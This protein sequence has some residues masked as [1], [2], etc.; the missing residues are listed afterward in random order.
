VIASIDQEAIMPVLIKFT[1][2]TG[3]VR[4]LG[5]NNKPTEHR[6]RAEP[7]DRK[8]A[9][10]I[11]LGLLK[12][13]D[14]G[15]VEIVEQQS[16]PAYAKAIEYIALNDEPRYLEVEEVIGLPTVHLTATLWDLKP[17][18]VALDVIAYRK[19]NT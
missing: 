7:F 3:N 14:A 19:K 10:K 8:T 1:S 11:Y 17:A 2:S 13:F 12:I 15:T 16:R 18:E 5:K 6:Q 4:W 9:E